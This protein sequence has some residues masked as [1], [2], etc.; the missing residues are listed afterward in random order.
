[1]GYTLTTRENNEM[2]MPLRNS[3][4]SKIAMSKIRK[5]SHKNKKINWNS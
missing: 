2:M 1:M 3:V 5:L 4:V